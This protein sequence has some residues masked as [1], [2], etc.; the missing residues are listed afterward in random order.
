MIRGC[1]VCDVCL[2]E[3]GRFL[4]A[5]RTLR[6]R[7]PSDSSVWELSDVPPNPIVNVFVA[8]LNTAWLANRNCTPRLYRIN[9]IVS[10]DTWSGV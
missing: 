4:A 5:H 10:R 2:L 9:D 7:G 3:N 6:S 8:H 1:T